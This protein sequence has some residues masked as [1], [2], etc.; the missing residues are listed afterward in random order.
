MG[1][2]YLRRQLGRLAQR[3]RTGDDG[4]ERERHSDQGFHWFVPSLK[5]AQHSASKIKPQ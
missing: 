1:R 2:C 5:A 3:K 4:G